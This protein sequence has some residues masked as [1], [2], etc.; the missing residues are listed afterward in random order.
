M[1][2]ALVAAFTAAS[3]LAGCRP[4]DLRSLEGT[5]WHSVRIVDTAPIGGQEPTLAFAAGGLTGTSVCTSFTV[6]RVTLDLE[7]HPAHF[8][9]HDLRVAAV[10][11]CLGKPQPQAEVAFWDAFGRSEFIE[12]TGGQLILKGAGGAI[13]FAQVPGLP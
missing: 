5:Q 4:V 6:P 1:R 9:I 10:P 8:T 12:L 7:A 3:L 2:Q 13:V 11:A